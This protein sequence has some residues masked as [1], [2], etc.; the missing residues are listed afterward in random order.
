MAISFY[1]AVGDRWLRVSGMGVSRKVGDEPG[2]GMTGW[3]MPAGG[4]WMG[5]V[6]Q[7]DETGGGSSGRSVDVMEVRRPHE[8]GD[9]ANLGLTLPEAKQ[10]LARVQQAVVPVQAE[11]HAVARPD[12]SCC[13]GGCHIQD[14]R[15]RQVATLFGL[16]AV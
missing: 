3:P 13:G 2:G 1:V 15:V 12:C 14:W 8:L 10:I 6:L 11:D 5:G 9:I 4:S 7:L 16:V